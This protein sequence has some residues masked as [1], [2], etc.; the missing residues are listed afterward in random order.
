MLSVV[1]DAT[2]SN[3]SERI[4]AF[5]G[6]KTCDIAKFIGWKTNIPVVCVPTS[7]AT[8]VYTSSKIDAMPRIQDL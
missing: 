4:V 5:G 2:K 1:V 6:G 7:L 8:H 3:G